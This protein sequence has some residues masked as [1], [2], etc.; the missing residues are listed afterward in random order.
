MDTLF[1]EIDEDSLIN[2]YNKNKKEKTPALKS[3]K[4]DSDILRLK[5]DRIMN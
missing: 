5:T 4:M 2:D 1:D 3:N